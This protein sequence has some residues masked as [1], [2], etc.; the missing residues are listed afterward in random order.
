[1]APL[2]NNETLVLKGGNY[3]VKASGALDLQWQLDA[4]GFVTI[5]DGSF[6]GETSVIVDLPQC[7]IKIINASTNTLLLREIG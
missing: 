3:A 6:A 7:T 2:Q 5:P 1:M 4:E